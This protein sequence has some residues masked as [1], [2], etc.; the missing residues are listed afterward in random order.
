MNSAA[1]KMIPMMHKIPGND[2]TPFL[3]TSF[4]D[5]LG[6]RLDEDDGRGVRATKQSTKRCMDG[7]T[8]WG[9]ANTIEVM[10]V[11]GPG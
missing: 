7:I 4:C 3:R 5:I 1:S 9:Y 8:R 2:N 11:P 6:G 10:R